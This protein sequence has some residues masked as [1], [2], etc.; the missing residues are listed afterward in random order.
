VIVRIRSAHT[1]N[2]HHVIPGLKLCLVQPID[3]SEAA[4]NAIA[5]DCIADLVGHGEPDPVALM[6]V[7]AAVQGKARRSGAASFGIETPKFMILF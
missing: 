5:H 3:L 6:P 1:R 2:G 7:F 4:T